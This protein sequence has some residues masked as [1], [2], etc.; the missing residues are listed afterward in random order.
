MTSAS[1]L[2]LRLE[3]ELSDELRLALSQGP[4]ELP[5]GEVL[6]AL[7]ARLAEHVGPAVRLRECAARGPGPLQTALLDDQSELPN[8]E[9]LRL[10]ARSVAKTR[11]VRPARAARRMRPALVAACLLIACIAAAASYWVARHR[12]HSVSPPKL[13]SSASGEGVLRAEPAM[14]PAPRR[15]SPEPAASA[16]NDASAR[17]SLARP[18]ASAAVTAEGPSELELLREAQRL[19][20]TDPAAALAVV[21]RHSRLFPSGILAQERELVAINSLTRLGRTEAARARAASFLR[22]YPGSVHALRIQEL[23]GTSAPSAST[24]PEDPW[25]GAAGHAPIFSP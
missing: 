21:A 18:K 16:E 7:R 9:Q 8:R 14:E 1:P 24:R 22:Q 4:G 10:L 11:S 5:S 12:E 17:P 23:V 3:T 25:S 19:Q 6:G 13:S 2:L 15:L 20:A